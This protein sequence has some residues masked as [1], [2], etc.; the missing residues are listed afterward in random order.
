MTKTITHFFHKQLRVQNKNMYVQ[1]CIGSLRCRLCTKNSA[2][3]TTANINPPHCGL[4]QKAWRVGWAKWRWELFIHPD[5]L[6]V[7]FVP[8]SHYWLLAIPWTSPLMTMFLRSGLLLPPSW[9]WERVISQDHWLAEDSLTI[10][11]SPSF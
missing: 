6:Y 11:Q 3:L 4:L 9:I 10:S 2:N 5:N 1:S 7:V 8:L